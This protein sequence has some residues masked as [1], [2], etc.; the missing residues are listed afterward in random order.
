MKKSRSE[1]CP[2]AETNELIDVDCDVSFESVTEIDDRRKARSIFHFTEMHS[3]HDS[4]ASQ[5]FLIMKK[6]FLILLVQ[7]YQDVIKEIMN[8][9]VAP[10]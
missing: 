4:H 6:E 9:T 3:L 2:T 5:L 1:N 8:I 10:C 7:I